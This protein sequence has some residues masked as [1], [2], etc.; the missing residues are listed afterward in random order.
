MGSEMCIRDRCLDCGECRD[1]EDGPGCPCSSVHCKGV[2]GVAYGAE[3][4]CRDEDEEVGEHDW[5]DQGEVRSR[6]GLNVHGTERCARCGMLRDWS[7]EQIGADQT[8][9]YTA[10]SYPEVTS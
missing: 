1:D 9:R 5:R 8:D 3:P 7:T 4:E 2:T 10:Y 6:G